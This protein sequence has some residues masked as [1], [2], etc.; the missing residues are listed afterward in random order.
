MTYNNVIYFDNAA[1]TRKKPESVY[2]AFNYFVR[3]IGA[4]PGRGS[5]ILA[6]EASRALYQS[7]KAI[8]DYFG[9]P[10][11]K[12]TVFT[13]NAT[14]ASNLFL[15]G[16]LKKDDH[17]LISSFEHNAILRPVHKLM[18]EGII[19]YDILPL[20]DNGDLNEENIV[21]F[22]KPNTKLCVITLASNVTGK[23]LFDVK[24]N[25]FLHSKKIKVL[26]D[27][28]QGAGRTNI[29]MMRDEIDFLI[30]T[31]HKDLYGFPGTGGLCSL[32]TLHMDPLIQGGTGVHAETFTNPDIFP[33]RF[34]AGTLNMPSIWSLKAGV[35]FVLNNREIIIEKEKMLYKN[36]LKE[37]KSIPRIVYYGNNS[38]DNSLPII[39]FNVEG[40]NCQE[41]SFHLSESNICVRSGMH[42][43]ILAHKNLNTENIGTVRVSLDYYN[44]QNEVD[45]FIDAIKKLVE[46][47]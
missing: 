19:S 27:T 15:R 6:I 10:D 45:K 33:E 35:E 47:S 4:S 11:A 23:K 5:H 32:N 20:D 43:S 38:I 44:S 24:L 39:S 46:T 13:K 17:V 26:L 8:A 2:E 21:Q 9:C 25:K 18:E 12:N 3:E 40:M 14:E 37:L 22:I 41:V 34:E 36:L 42:C 28:A 16:F 7:R 1:T 29:N 30:F 31:G